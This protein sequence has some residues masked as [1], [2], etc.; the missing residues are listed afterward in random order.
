MQTDNKQLSQVHK[1]QLQKAANE[2]CAKVLEIQVTLL[3]FQDK[4]NNEKALDDEIERLQN[5]TPEEMAELRK[6]RLDDLKQKSEQREKWL[7]NHHGTVQTLAD[8]KQ[9]F[10]VMKSTQHVICMFFKTTS[11][12]CQELKQ[13]LS[14]LAEKH[15]ECKFVEMDGE[16]AP[17]LVERLSVTM[18]PAL[19]LARN[20]KVV[21]LLLGLDWVAPDGKLDTLKLE[22]KLFEYGFF[23]ETV[24]GLEKQLK[25]VK[26]EIARERE[27]DSDLD[28]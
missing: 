11:K 20:N 9:F 7:S 23:E 15:I 21:K 14:L 2:I 28:L 17:F 19:V 1:Y 25:E 6:K 22:E 10:E 4:H 16:K 27:S 13:H 24:L 12:W 3:L 18:I 26:Q 8:E 5:V